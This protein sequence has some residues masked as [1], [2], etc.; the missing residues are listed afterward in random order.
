MIAWI[1]TALSI[2]GI[3]LNAKKHIG[4][5]PVWITA[6]ILWAYHSIFEIPETS[7]LVLWLVFIIS[8]IYGWIEW[9]KDK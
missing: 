2:T 9:R 7:Q 6:N 8:N 3:F 5:W 1:A 4:C